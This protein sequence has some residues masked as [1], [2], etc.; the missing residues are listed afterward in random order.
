MRKTLASLLTLLGVVSLLVSLMSAY[1][2]VI[3]FIDRSKYGPGLLFADVE[4][5][6]AITLFF[7]IVGSAVLWISYRINKRPP[8]EDK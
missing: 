2:A 1:Y 7:I 4:I 5:F 6:T 8:P 3:S